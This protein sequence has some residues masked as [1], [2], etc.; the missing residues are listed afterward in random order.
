MPVSGIANFTKYIKGS[1]T[2]PFIIDDDN[3]ANRFATQLR[4]LGVHV[5]SDED[6]LQ[7]TA[8]LDKMEF[9]REGG[10][11]EVFVGTF[12]RQKVA[13]KKVKGVS[14]IAFFSGAQ[15]I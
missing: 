14:K 7:L 8:Q 9:V 2:S 10:F 12:A 11:G 3:P 15:A 6:I 4:S 1:A 13:L 5:Y